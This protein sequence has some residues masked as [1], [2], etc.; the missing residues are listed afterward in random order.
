MDPIT[1]IAG[2]G[3]SLIS[4]LFGKKGAEDQNKAQIASAREQMA[5][6]E[7]MSNTAHVREVADLKA[8]GLNPILSAKLGGASSPGGAQ[9]NIVNTMAPLASSA[10]SAADKLYNFRVQSAQVDNMKLQNEVLA[11]QVQQLKI[12]NAKQ[13]ILTPVYSA[14]GE[15][16]DWMTAKG[17]EAFGD[18][19]DILQ[20]V[21]D[22]GKSAAGGISTDPS[23]AKS[24]F[25]FWRDRHY[26]PLG[27]KDSEARKYAKGEKGFW[28]SF[29]DAQRPQLTED[30]LRS[31][32]MKHL[33]QI[34]RR[35]G[36]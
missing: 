28:Q 25:D 26:L 22:A 13:G 10:Q 19:P 4:G 15:A 29:K 6:Q 27:T 32:G 36:K 7:R 2:I 33:Q 23:S 16:V 12:S 11:Q 3:G 18:V 14:A 1:A 8:A 31:Y 20:G 5:F 30:S 21:L 9:P 24:N 35:A 17:R 34:K